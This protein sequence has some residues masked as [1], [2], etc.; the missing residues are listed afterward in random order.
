MFPRNVFHFCHTGICLISAVKQKHILVLECFRC[1]KTKKYWGT[2]C[3]QQMFL[4]TLILVLPGFYDVA[5]QKRLKINWK[6]VC[7]V[8]L[9]CSQHFFLSSLEWKQNYVFLITRSP[10]LWRALEF[11]TDFVC[12]LVSL[13]GSF[14]HSLFSMRTAFTFT[15]NWRATVHIEKG[16]MP[17]TFVPTFK[18]HKIT[19][20]SSFYHLSF[21]LSFRFIIILACKCQAS[22]R[23]D[24]FSWVIVKRTNCLWAE[25]RSR[26]FR[27]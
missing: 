20:K 15:L 23:M 21:C 3:P 13:F 4:V 14:G 16:L 9:I 25:G 17:E 1:R 24:C 10:F 2:M 12:L 6:T 11:S 18:L 5:K 27:S 26:T 7:V 22:T 8:R 19:I